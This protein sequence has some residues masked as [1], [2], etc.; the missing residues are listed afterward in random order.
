MFSCAGEGWTLR[1]GFSPSRKRP[2]VRIV[3]RTRI[4]IIPRA[5]DISSAFC[6]FA[7][8]E[9]NTSIAERFNFRHS[10]DQSRALHAHK[11]DSPRDSPASRFS[12]NPSQPTSASARANTTKINTNSH[13][14]TIK[15][16]A[17]PRRSER[18]APSTLCLHRAGAAPASPSR[19]RD[20][21][22]PR[23]LHSPNAFIEKPRRS[24]KCTLCGPN[25]GR[26]Q[27]LHGRNNG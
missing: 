8:T 11:G 7:S 1:A 26:A 20:F 19:M 24:A 13:E 6:T 16:G 15:R 2:R 23:A 10:S 21:T 4:N 9:F 14:N 27:C 3:N 12:T 22:V 5:S 17:N 18:S 25:L